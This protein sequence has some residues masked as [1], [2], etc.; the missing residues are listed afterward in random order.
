[1]RSAIS[2]P[3]LITFLLAA[4][5]PAP[6]ATTPAP[7]TAVAITPSAS[8]L[9]AHDQTATASAGHPPA[10]HVTI[11]PLPESAFT[12]SAT[13]TIQIDS[14]SRFQTFQG[15]GATFRPFNAPLSKLDDPNGPDFTTATD[16]QRRAIADILYRQIGLTRTRFFPDQFEP[17][18]DN[19]DPFS[20]DPAAYDW[21][22]V[23]QLT[24]FTALGKSLDLQTPWLSFGVDLGHTQT[25]L[26]QPDS[27]ALNPAMLDEDVEWILAAALHFRDTGQEPPYLTI[28]NEPDL[29]PPGYKIEIAD[30]VTLV[31]RLGARLRE[32]GLTTQIVVTDGWIPQNAFLYMQAV[33]ADPDARQYVGALATHAYADGYDDP[34]T[35]LNNSAQ[36][37]PSHAAAEVRA[38]LRDLAAQYTLPLWITEICY[39]T[40]R[41]AEFSEFD[42]LR[43]R[44]NHLH[45]ELTLANASAFDA[46]NLYNIRRPGVYDELVEVFY[47][48]DGSMER[49]QL[50]TYGQ[51]LSQYALNILPGS[52]RLNAESSD[53][54]VRVLAFIRPDGK[55]VV[56]A[57]NNNSTAVQAN[58]N[59]STTFAILISRD[60]AIGQTAPD[61]TTTLALPPLS[62][63]T[64]VER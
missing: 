15:F 52:V 41:S 2:F 62:L 27:C 50:S 48:P 1:M 36:G 13:V 60:G 30:Y 22:Q 42:L 58:L 34:A 26:R 64:L 19:A 57:L 56:V 25:W 39:C 11:T 5:L 6:S 16:E 31:K 38:K 12:P 55:L 49:Y 46:M 8:A 29:C 40:P 3:T 37:N 28:N 35:V 4:C 7:P 32:Q 54:R 17:A 61:V 18:N 63:T 9:T 53:P 43:A 51:L 59:T 33:L 45:D 23:D 21:S 14:A 47:R 10:V 20:F 24:E 44:L